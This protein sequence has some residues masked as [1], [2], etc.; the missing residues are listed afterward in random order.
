M[1]KHLALAS[2][3]CCA[4]LTAIT[5]HADCDKGSK[6]VFSCVSGKGKLIEVCDSKKTITY[7]YGKPKAK[8]E[9]V[10]TVPRNAASTIQYHRGSSMSYSVDIPNGNTIYS[11]FW[12]VENAQSSPIEAGVSVAVNSK[13]VATVACAGEA[14][15]EMEGI[16][17]KPTE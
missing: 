10:V 17:L 6:T 4:S 8:P 5:A 3:V 9:I 14:Y 1:F 7:S 16:D 13:H 2:V 15:Q 12:G 11:V